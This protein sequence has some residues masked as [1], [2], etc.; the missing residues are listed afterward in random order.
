MRSAVESVL[1]TGPDK[2]PGSDRFRQTSTVS[3]NMA[4]T[5]GMQYVLI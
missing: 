3:H 4:H 5:G 2:A 1:S